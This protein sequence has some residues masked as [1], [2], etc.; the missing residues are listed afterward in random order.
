MKKTKL[1][2]EANGEGVLFQLSGNKK[3]IVM[4]ICLAMYDSNEFEQMLG[5]ALQL[6]FSY[7]LDRHGIDPE[8]FMREAEEQADPL[9]EVLQRAVERTHKNG[10]HRS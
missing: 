6:M 8:A 5:M 9:R 1:L 4:A 7:Q 3:D 2:I 10:G